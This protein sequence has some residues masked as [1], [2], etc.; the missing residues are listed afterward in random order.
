MA[1][2]RYT[3]LLAMWRIVEADIDNVFPI[4][5]INNPV[6][7]HAAY[8]VPAG[9]STVCTLAG[10]EDSN[11]ALTFFIT[12]LPVRGKLYETSQNFRSYGINP[13]EAPK[14]IEDHELPFVVTDAQHR[15]VYEPPQDAFPP[16]G[17]WASFTYVVKEPLSGV[18]S[19]TGY[20]VLN[21]PANRL[22]ASGFVGGY[23]EW[24]ISGNI[25]SVSPAF[26]PV[27]WGSLD[28]YIYGID[29][30]QYTDF[31]TGSDNTK[32]YFEAPATKYLLP[33]FV[34]T[35]GGLIR[36]T[37]KSTYGDF[38]FLNDPLDWVTLECSSCNMGRGLR[39]VRFADKILSF[40]GSEKTVTIPIKANQGWRRDPLNT[41][42]PFTDATECEIAAVLSGVTKF[43]ILG[44]FTQAGEGVALDDVMVESAPEQP[45]YPTACQQGC[46]CSH[47]QSI[48]RLACCGS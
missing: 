26:E 30:V 21:N 20:V 41:A 35:Y 36:F 46:V 8:P 2:I 11:K 25:H 5:Y 29:E 19:E 15:V 16:E 32:W 37:T 43:K 47:H 22:A 9:V 23:D 4:V 44:D 3:A 13:K 24:K 38:N 7:R 27:A 28:R 45:A 14:P 40:D 34:G 39:I 42:M 18:T 17:F 6:A 10:H 1:L 33:E 31:S 48:R 12:T